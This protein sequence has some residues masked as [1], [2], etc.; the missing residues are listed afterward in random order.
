[1]VFFKQAKVYFFDL[2]PAGRIINRFSSDTYTIDDS[3]PFIMNILLAQ[4]FGLIGKYLCTFFQKLPDENLIF[5]ISHCDYV[6]PTVALP[7]TRASCPFVSLAAAL[8]PPYFK[9]TETNQQCGLI[10]CLQPL[11]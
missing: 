2:T 8:L 7:C 3:L 5:R 4:L 10:P 6:W 11:Q 9:G 1:M